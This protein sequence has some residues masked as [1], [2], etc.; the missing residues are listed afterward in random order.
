VNNAKILKLGV[1]NRHNM[2]VEAYLVNRD[3]EAGQD[4]YRA[5]FEAA[6][7]LGRT[8][9]DI[10]HLYYTGLTES[11]IGALDGLESYGVR[12]VLYR[13]DNDS[14]SY[15][16]LERGLKNPNSLEESHRRFWGW[17]S[18]PLCQADRADPS[19]MFVGKCLLRPSS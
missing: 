3:V 10:I 14:L 8:G 13:Y 9:V 18:C 15:V 11:T 4:A 7:E 5:A 6:L 19:G 2:P 1:L 12:V 16:P 17:W